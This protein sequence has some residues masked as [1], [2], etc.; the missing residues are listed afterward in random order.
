MYLDQRRKAKNRKFEQLKREVDELERQFWE[1]SRKIA[2][3]SEHIG[4]KQPFHNR[5]NSP[6]YKLRSGKPA[7]AKI[8]SF[9]PGMRPKSNESRKPASLNSEKALSGK[10]RTNSHK[11]FFSQPKSPSSSPGSPRLSVQLKQ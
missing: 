7:T 3:M 5:S 6:E 11:S 10:N 2:I 4:Y 9:W 8:D 1:D